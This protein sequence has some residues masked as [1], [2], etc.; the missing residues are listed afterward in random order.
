MGA[1]RFKLPRWRVA[2]L[3]DLPSGGTSRVSVG[4]PAA[5]RWVTKLADTV[6]HSPRDATFR[7]VSGGITVV[8]SQQGRALDVD[9]SIRAVE[10]AAFSATNRT[11]ALVV[12][13][14][15][16]SRT[17]RDAEAMGITAVPTLFIN[18]QRHVGPYDSQSLLR[19]LRETGASPAP[20]DES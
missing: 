2:Q 6:G 15:E 4:G 7:V 9:A 11:A 13:A 17:T 12:H 10:R 8:P 19:A 16:P 18:G 5:R 20:V 3:L 14:A 1:A